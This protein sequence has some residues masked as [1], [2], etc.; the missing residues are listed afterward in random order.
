MQKIILNLFCFFFA[1]SSFAQTLFNVDGEDVSVSEFKRMYQKSNPD[2]DFSEESVK[3][4][5]EL[6]VKYKL[7]LKE[8][9]AK[10][11][12]QNPEVLREIA[13][14]EE[15]LIQNEFDKEMMN[16]L[17]AEVRNRLQEELCARHIL[18]HLKR[19][20]SPEDTLIAY[21]W[22][23]R[24]RERLLNGSSFEKQAKIESAD[25][26]TKFNGGDLGCFTALQL[27]SY[28]L[29]NALYKMRKGEISMPIRTR[30]GYHIIRLDDRRPT[31]GF[32]KA[33]QLFVRANKTQ[34]EEF[35][36]EA[37][38]LIDYA[39]AQLNAGEKFNDV[40]AEFLL[41]ENENLEVSKDAIDWFSVGSYESTFEN[42]IFSLAKKGDYSKPIQTSLGWHIFRL[43]GQKDLPKFEDIESNIRDM[44]Q[45][46][47]RYFK[48]KMRYSERLKQKY[49]F[50]KNEENV[51]LF[52]K[53][54]ARGI[55][56]KGWQIPTIY[57]LNSDFFTIDSTRVFSARQFVNYV[58]EQHHQD[59]FH[60]FDYYY[61]NFESNNL[62]Q[63]HKENMVKKSPELKA[64]MKEYRDGII[65]FNL[66]E[67]EL[68][69][70]KKIKD[71]D[72]KTYYQENVTQYKHPDQVKVR[73]Y[74]L[75]T[76]ETKKV[77]KLVKYLKANKGEYMIRKLNS[78]SKVIDISD[79]Y[80]TASE[81]KE[82]GITPT[83]IGSYARKKG[84]DYITF[85][86]NEKFQPGGFRDFS[87]VKSKVIL[88]YQK[89]KE[90][91]WI[92]DLKKKYK[93]DINEQSLSN[94][95]K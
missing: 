56:I 50:E 47:E 21:N 10:G 35:N 11:Y 32:V 28:D 85:Y 13:M 57:D 30:S 43:D 70:E 22:S 77:K 94:L 91:S 74:K 17:I 63:Y 87:A 44:I 83:K 16:E 81:A 72:V 39:Y 89:K 36:V 93:V 61:K 14:Y 90:D 6:Y 41:Q 2:G 18:I 82:L 58:K 12:Y 76:S 15:K 69:S 60:S 84:G 68:W 46:D 48:S 19:R 75:P 51:D 7:K 25:I 92:S 34:K 24:V 59:H 65:L 49:S 3:N 54:V 23:M 55:D 8:A 45:E 66:M 67:K 9:E 1:I 37:K 52:I 4:Y 20:P 26:D 31:K 27:S 88:D 86:K 62:L 42:G 38:Q 73:V 71:D 95:Y 64:L 40:S 79:D 53:Q 78:P 29:E 80:L 33:T 5:L